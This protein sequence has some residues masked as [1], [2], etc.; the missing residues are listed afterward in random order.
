MSPALSGSSAIWHFEGNDAIEIRDKIT[1]DFYTG[2]PQMYVAFL[3]AGAP[4]SLRHMWLP[5]LLNISTRK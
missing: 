3:A 4:A 1:F 2:L 5:S